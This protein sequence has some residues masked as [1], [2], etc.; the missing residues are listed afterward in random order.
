MVTKHVNVGVVHTILLHKLRVCNCGN[1]ANDDVA[2]NL[3]IVSSLDCVVCGSCNIPEPNSLRCGM[4][5]SS[6]LSRFKYFNLLK[7]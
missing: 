2:S 3:L 5:T 4:L 7:E 6:L 1:G